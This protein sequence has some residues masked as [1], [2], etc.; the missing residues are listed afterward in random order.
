MR[1][2][3]A[4]LVGAAAVVLVGLGFWYFREL[5]SNWQGKSPQIAEGPEGHKKESCL[6]CHQPHDNPL[7]K[8]NACAKC[9]QDEAAH[10]AT[11]PPP[12]HRLCT[13]CHEKHVF[14]IPDPKVACAKC[15]GPMFDTALPGQEM[16][17]RLYDAFQKAGL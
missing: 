15:H 8:E 3:S 13:S 11:A 4:V 17:A 6:G 14:S 7:P 12:K 5:G 1:K 10:V 2:V 9:H 16:N